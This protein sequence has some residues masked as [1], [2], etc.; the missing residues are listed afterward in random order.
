MLEEYDFVVKGLIAGI[1]A[2][3]A[4][5]LGALPLLIPRLRVS[6][7]IHLGYGFA[8]G[9]MFAASVYNLLLPA[10]N[11]GTDRAM[12]LWSV[13]NVV[14]GLMLGCA[15]IWLVEQY[16]TP[17]RL[18]SSVIL[19]SF[20]SRIET[21]VFVAMFFHSIPEGVAVGVGYGAETHGGSFSRLGF[22]IALAIAI[23]NIPEG[24]AVALPMRAR[25]ASI[26]KCFWFAVLTSLPQP[27]AAVPASMLVWF[28]EPLMLPLLGFAA[29]AMMYLVIDELIPEALESGNHTPIT[30]AF[31][32]GFSVMVLVQVVL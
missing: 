19:K 12:Q 26:W 29:G 18:E 10:F 30:W 28:F 31:M 8:G 23:H 13:G 7:R 3:L 15:F 11:Q 6:E 14:F 20:D 17:Q 4:C 16:V 24:L 27:L 9:L 2:S 32:I 21:L 22:S 25:G 5:G 1:F